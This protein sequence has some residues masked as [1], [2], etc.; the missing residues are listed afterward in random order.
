MHVQAMQ[1]K[2]SSSKEAKRLQE[3]NMRSN[4]KRLMM[5]P[6]G[7]HAHCGRHTGGGRGDG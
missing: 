1:R 5:M 7:R 4:S 6:D 3:L 2:N